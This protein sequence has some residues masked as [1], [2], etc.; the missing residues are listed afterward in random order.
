MCFLKDPSERAPIQAVA[1]QEMGAI[2]SSIPGAVAFLQPNPALEISTGA[3]ANL[4][5]EFA[6][7]LSG[8]DAN[9][10]YATAAKL[11]GKMYQYPGFLFV[12]S[13]LFNHTPNLQIDILREQ[14]KLYGV[15]E[16]RIS[17]CFTTL[18]LKITAT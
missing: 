15:S 10:V 16:S 2:A 7:T 11:T 17:T 13:D 14:A 1:G 4:Q 12:N 9:Q 3:T 8:I 18:T 6:Y 5:G